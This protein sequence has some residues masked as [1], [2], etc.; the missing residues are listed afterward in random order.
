MGLQAGGWPS[1]ER[2]SFYVVDGYTVAPSMLK[3]ENSLPAHCT[4]VHGDFHSDFKR[5]NGLYV[6]FSVEFYSGWKLNF[7][8][9]TIVRAAILATH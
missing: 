6:Y 1:I 4:V 5:E 9:N 2:P 3:V 8:T 7:F